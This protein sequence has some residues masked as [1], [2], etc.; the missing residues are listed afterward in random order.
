MNKYFGQNPNRRGYKSA[1]FSLIEVMIVV[2]IL[3]II[4][5][6]GVPSYSS[7]M[8]KTRRAD[9]IA[10]LSEVAGEQERFFTENNRYATTMT[11]MGYTAATELSENG[12]Y[13]VSVTASGGTTFTLTA[14]P[15][16]GEPQENDTKCGSFTINSA[17]SKGVVNASLPAEKCW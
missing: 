13:G 14:A 9:A 3:G 16:A 7:Y 8:E 15:I 5:G 1:G 6:I 12:F 2:A 11:E 17:G 10:L 4:L